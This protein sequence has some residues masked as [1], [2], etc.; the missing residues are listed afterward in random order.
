MAKKRKKQDKK[1]TSKNSKSK[2]SREKLLTNEEIVTG[3]LKRIRKLEEIHEQRKKQHKPADAIAYWTFLFLILVTNFFVSFILVFLILTIQHALLYVVV[4]IMGL[5][6]GLMYEKIIN[7]MSHLYKHHHVF[8][9]I[10]ILVTGAINVFYIVT[11][12]SIIFVFFNM[13]NEVYN[14]LGIGVTYF[15]AFLIPYFLALGAKRQVL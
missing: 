2:N 3:S 7:N 14:H 13:R 12:S 10:F 5:G 1:K 6:F 9:K 11:L 4:I 8:A 15:F